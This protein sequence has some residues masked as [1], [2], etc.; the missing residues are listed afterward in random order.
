MIVGDS[1]F[2]D[3]GDKMEDKGRTEDCTELDFTVGGQDV[4]KPSSVMLIHYGRW[5]LPLQ[6]PCK[7]I[8]CVNV[9]ERAIKGRKIRAKEWPRRQRERD[10]A[11][12]SN[13][14]CLIA[15]GGKKGEFD[16]T[17]YFV[18]TLS[19]LC[20]H[21]KYWQMDVCCFKAICCFEMFCLSFL[22]VEKLHFSFLTAWNRRN[23]CLQNLNR[24]NAPL[25][26]TEEIFLHIKEFRPPQKQKQKQSNIW[27]LCG[28]LK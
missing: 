18:S 27:E 9:H 11:G 10:W 12:R 24:A 22:R 3:G 20:L 28:I 4:S 5:Y 23:K 19:I 26:L 21:R 17:E 8:S 13:A 16:K 7:D 6:L 14:E 15:A 25:R 1:R 2:T